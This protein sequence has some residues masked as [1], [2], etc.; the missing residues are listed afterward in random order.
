MAGGDGPEEA[1]RKLLQAI[2]GV[3][4]E[5]PSG[6]C[7]ALTEVLY[8]DLRRLAR[9]FL[10]RERAGHSLS[11]TELVHEAY[12]RLVEQVRV[13]L[14][15]RAHFLALAAQ[16][17]R[18]LLVDHARHRSRTK[19]GGDW[20]RVTLD[21]GLGAAE[22]AENVELEEVLALDGALTKLESV[23]PREARI[24]ELRYFAG[25]EVAEIATALGISKRTVDR[26]WLHA[27]SWLKRE[28]SG[29]GE[30]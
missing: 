7:D 16:A 22:A 19:R 21:P 24:V 15:G 10:S 26:D 23:D 3:A 18:R 20:Q 1:A 29:D 25:M 14:T 12:Q 30:S 9:S 28:L 4:H 6:A 11:P 5:A 8:E 17:M 27:R 13:D 2:T